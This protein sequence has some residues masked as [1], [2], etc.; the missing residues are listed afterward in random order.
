MLCSGSVNRLEGRIGV[1]RE[2]PQPWAPEQRDER[3]PA[4]QIGQEVL[5]DADE[6]LVVA[7]SEREVGRHVLFFETSGEVGGNSVLD[8]V[9]E[10]VPELLDAVAHVLP[11]GEHLL[12]LVEYEHRGEGK[13]AVAPQLQM[14]GVQV[15]PDR[16]V[17][18][19]QPGVRHLRLQGFPNGL[20]KLVRDRRSIGLEVEA[21]V[22]RQVVVLAQAGEE[23]S[24]KKRGLP[25][26]RSAEENGDR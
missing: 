20:P 23:R 4:L 7:R 19:G 13:I 8:Q 9:A 26:P 25:E 5:P 16:L 21:D 11:E 1:H 18:A 6:Q 15:L 22:D 3:A 10:I 12:E 14:S 24:P 17:V 2:Q